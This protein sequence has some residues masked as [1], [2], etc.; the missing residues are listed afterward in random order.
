[1]FFCDCCLT[2]LETNMADIGGQRIR[3][4]ERNMDV[5]SKEL[6]EIM[7]LLRNTNTTSTTPKN[8]E[9]T[10]KNPQQTTPKLA[11]TTY[12][13]W[14]DTDKLASK[15]AKPAE[16]VLVINK[17]T[18]SLVDKTNIDLV[19]NMVIECRIPVTKSF[20]NKDGHL[21]VVCDSVES[22][23]ELKNKVTASNNNIEMKTPKE[24]RP[25][26][27]VVGL[28]KNYEKQE[29][30]DL[31]VKQNYFLGQVMEKNN[32]DEHINVFMVKPLRGK[33]YVYQAFARVSKVV[34]QSF[35]TYNE[36]KIYDQYHV[37][38]CNN[39]Q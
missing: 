13:I 17:A 23:D 32:V 12:N 1:M 39:C 29:V 27:S 20:K 16:S 15:K 4:M 33:Q 31:L 21:V 19:E 9:S 34:R 35:K 11:E 3:K 26:V 18:D 14:R 6:L 36:C 2:T 22:R 7:K 10:N 24:N 28:T 8:V 37:K 5:I 25:V 38:R 30:T